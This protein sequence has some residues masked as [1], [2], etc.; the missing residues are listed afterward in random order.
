MD[1]RDDWVTDPATVIEFG[2]AFI[3]ANGAIDLGEVAEATGYG[4]VVGTG[5]GSAIGAG[6]QFVSTAR[7]DTGSFLKG[8][9]VLVVGSAG[10]SGAALAS[11]GG[12]TQVDVDKQVGGQVAGGIG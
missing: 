8:S 5:A 10:L 12:A 3:H 7:G 6:T 11:L 4:A 9:G 2:D 1:K